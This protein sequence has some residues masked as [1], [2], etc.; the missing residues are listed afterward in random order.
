VGLWARLH[1]RRRRRR[2]VDGPVAGARLAVR[3][4]W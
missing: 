2:C 3:L 1:A 4:A